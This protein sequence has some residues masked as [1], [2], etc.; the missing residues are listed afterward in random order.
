[1][2]YRRGPSLSSIIIRQIAGRGTP[3]FYFISAGFLTV[4]AII[5]LT[6]WGGQKMAYDELLE[7]C[8]ETTTGEVTYVSSTYRSGK[9]YAYV[10][11]TAFARD[12]KL[13]TPLSLASKEVGD[14]VTVHFNSIDPK[15]AYAYEGPEPAN[16]RFQMYG[17]ITLVLAMVDVI[18]GI[19]KKRKGVQNGGMIGRAEARRQAELNGTWGTPDPKD[20]QAARDLM[21]NY[22]GSSQRSSE[23]ELMDLLS[24]KGR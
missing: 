12:Y 6:I 20:I 16:E 19:S 24:R 2:A 8:N 4:I 3:A 11:F 9:T 21:M 22:N 7:K 23:Q 13:K 14:K 18:F 15:M 5:F 1:M 17:V 10:A